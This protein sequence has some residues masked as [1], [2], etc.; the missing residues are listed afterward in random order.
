VLITVKSK[1]GGAVEVN[2]GGDGAVE[3]GVT[4]DEI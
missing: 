2:V 1:V 4:V 3:V